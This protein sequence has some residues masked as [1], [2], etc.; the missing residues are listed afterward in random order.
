[1]PFRLIPLAL[2]AAL[3]VMFAIGAFDNRGNADDAFIVDNVLV[4]DVLS[5][6]DGVLDEAL[7]EDSFDWLNGSINGAA[8]TVGDGVESVTE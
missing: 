5:E 6:V 3:V 4:D 7:H 2:V 1:M 8:D